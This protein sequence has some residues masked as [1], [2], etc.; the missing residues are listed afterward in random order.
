MEASNCPSNVIYTYNET[1]FSH[2][3]KILSHATTCMIMS[4]IKPHEISQSYKNT[5]TVSF[6]L[7][8]IANIV[9]Q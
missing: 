6:Y 5:N 2:I 3:K 7:Y 9:K 8:E 1:L 4:D